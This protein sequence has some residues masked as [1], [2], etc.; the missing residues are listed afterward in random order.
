VRDGQDKFQGGSEQNISEAPVFQQGSS[1]EASLSPS[2]LL[3]DA[4]ATDNERV[5]P[6]EDSPMKSSETSDLPAK[7]PPDKKSR[8][9]QII[10]RETAKCFCVFK[11]NL[12]FYL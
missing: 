7:D 2:A 11:H 4:S 12:F 9:L 5:K 1:A 8:R 10:Y 3:D 6:E